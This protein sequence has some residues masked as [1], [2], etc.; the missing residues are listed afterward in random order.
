MKYFEINLTR[1]D[2]DSYTKNYKIF[3]RETEEAPSTWKEIQCSWTERL[4]VSI[5]FTQIDL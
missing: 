3:L 2:Q 1:Y 4:N 5:I